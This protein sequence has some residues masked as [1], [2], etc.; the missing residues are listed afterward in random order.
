MHTCNILLAEDDPQQQ[1]LL[2][3][4]IKLYFKAKPITVFTT[5]CLEEA[6]NLERMSGPMAVSIIDLQLKD[7]APENTMKHFLQLGRCVIALS[8]VA[9]GA[10]I[11]DCKRYGARDYVEKPVVT[12]LLIE[13]IARFLDNMEPGHEFVDVQ[14]EAQT[15]LTQKTVAAP[16]IANIQLTAPLSKVARIVIPSVGVAATTVAAAGGFMIGGWRTAVSTGEE[17]QGAKDKLAQIEVQV[18]EIK[19]SDKERDR[20]MTKMQNDITKLL[21]KSGWEDKN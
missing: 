7:S 19:D 15:A 2:E 14:R 18:R 1:F 20:A 17:K 21:V 16:P 9:S 10:S 11:R 12:E 5:D 3:R 4:A 13:K 8:G 6:I